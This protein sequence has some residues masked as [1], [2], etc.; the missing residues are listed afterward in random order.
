MKMLKSF[1]DIERMNDLDQ[2]AIASDIAI[3]KVD[4]GF[5]VDDYKLRHSIFI[6]IQRPPC[7][8]IIKAYRKTKE[9][10]KLMGKQY[11]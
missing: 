4:G 10:R 9:F 5:I 11:E 1:S 6:D 3:I 8:V 2:I 7:K